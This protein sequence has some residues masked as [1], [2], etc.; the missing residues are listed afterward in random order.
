MFNLFPSFQKPEWLTDTGYTI[1]GKNYSPAELMFEFIKLKNEL[2]S[3]EKD[4]TEE[5][6][7]AIKLREENVELKKILIDLKEENAQLKLELENWKR[8]VTAWRAQ[9]DQEV[10]KNTKLED[11][12][13]EYKKG[14]KNWMNLY[15]E[16][17]DMNNELLKEIK[18]LSYLKE[19]NVELIDRVNEIDSDQN[20]E[21]RAEIFTLKND[22]ALLRAKNNTLQEF[23]DTKIKVDWKS[24]RIDILERDLQKCTEQRDEF[25]HQLNAANKENEKLKKDIVDYVF[26]KDN[27]VNFFEE[28]LKRL[29]SITKEEYDKIPVV[30]SADIIGNLLQKVKDLT[31]GVEV[32]LDKPLDEQCDKEDEPAFLKCA[33]GD[34]HEKT[35]QYNQFH[36]DMYYQDAYAEKKEKSWEEAASDLALK[37]TKLEEQLKIHKLLIDQ[38]NKYIYH[39]KSNYRI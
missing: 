38:L 36:D 14:N 8:G 33:C 37:V 30:G 9:C 1:E 11:E 5:H 20:E 28:E 23:I 18:H 27:Q 29:K 15:Q 35:K 16:V 7:N 26:E 6:N 3:I 25:K 4:G 2:N 12:I 22:I 32:D 34:C 10:A 17:V 19:K 39:A 24:A 31:E 21:Y 13:T